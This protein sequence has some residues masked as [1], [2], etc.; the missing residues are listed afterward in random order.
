MR[1]QQ[2]TQLEHYESRKAFA[3]RWGFSLRK[4]DEL[5]GSGAIPVIRLSPRM[6]RIPSERADAAL[7]RL[8]VEEVAS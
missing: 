6:I 7:R 1:T 5:I 3:D 8:E 4:M 2:D